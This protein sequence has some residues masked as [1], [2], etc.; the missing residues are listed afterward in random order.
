MVVEDAV[1]CIGGAGDTRGLQGGDAS[2][3]RYATSKGGDEDCP[4]HRVFLGL[5]PPGLVHGRPVLV[6]ATQQVI[7]ESL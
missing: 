1:A 7:R 3:S 4:T 6:L 2:L 5:K